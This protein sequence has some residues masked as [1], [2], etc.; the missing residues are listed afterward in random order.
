[1]DKV[2]NINFTG[3]RNIGSM[4]FQREGR[5]VAKNISMT[6]H[7][8]IYGKDLQEFTEILK[9]INGGRYKN[10][11]Y[12]HLLNV[13]CQSTMDGHRFLSVNNVILEEKDKNLPMFSYIAK[14]TRK[15]SEMP[16][17]NMIV[18][19]DYKEIAGR[20][21]LISG[22]IIENYDKLVEDGTIE[23]I[24]NED[25]VKDAAKKVNNFIS[26]MMNAYFDI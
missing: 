16:K 25:W 24:F 5:K 8:D 7:D 6:L 4:Q 3:I 21:T 1:M 22:N 10:G 9:K 2:N 20:E 13:E 18:N 11:E 19:N 23:K 15:I 14:L 12:P 26:K 17:E